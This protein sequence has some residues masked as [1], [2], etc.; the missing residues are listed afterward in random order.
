[1]ARKPNFNFEKRSK[2][3]ARQ[4]KR[5]RKEEEKLRRKREGEAENQPAPPADP[6]ADVE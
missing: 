2:E 4:A 1:L 5:D 3:L 6:N